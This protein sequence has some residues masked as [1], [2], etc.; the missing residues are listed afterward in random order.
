MKKICLIT[1]SELIVHFFLI[2]PLRVL[3]REYD[4]SLIVKTDNSGFLDDYGLNVR[5]IPVDIEREIR[6]LADLRALFR[7][8]MLFRR[9]KFA[10]VHSVAPKAGLLTMLA[11]VLTGRPVR[12]HTMIGQVWATRVGLP[13][14][15]LKNIDRLT[16]TLATHLLADSQSQA[17][18]VLAEGVVKAGK[19]QVLGDGSIAGVDVRRFKADMQARLAIRAEL[20]TPEQAKVV[21]FIGRLKRDKGVLDLA[22]AFAMLDD[23]QKKICLW[24]VGPDEDGLGDE[25]ES[26]CGKQRDRLHL[27]GY[28]RHA[29]RYMAAADVFCLPSYRE[30]FGVTTLEAAACGLPSV[31]SRIYGIIDAIQEGKTGLLNEAGHVQ[32]LADNLQQLL[33]DEALRKQLGEAAYQRVLRDFS[34][35]RVTGLWLD[36]YQSLLKPEAE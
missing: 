15:I 34:C 33:T 31:G 8:I 7:L 32:D 2:E 23:P 19:I 22:R 18:F 5:V 11:A 13:R 26:I 36:F 21:L 10:A 12:I 30:G 6:P 35:Q 25:I 14:F 28:T 3:S 20:D 16:A 4:V 24:I 9:E 29:E 1:S 27:H 17:D